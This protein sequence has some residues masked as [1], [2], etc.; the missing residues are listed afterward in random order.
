[1]FQQGIETL[2]LVKPDITHTLTCL[3]EQAFLD[4]LLSN[5]EGC[6][7]VLIIEN[8][9]SRHRLVNAR[10]F[11]YDTNRVERWPTDGAYGCHIQLMTRSRNELTR[12]TTILL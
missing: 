11:K 7:T 8:H 6:K 5:F 2:T 3:V 9:C 12:V 4:R 1:M 10:F